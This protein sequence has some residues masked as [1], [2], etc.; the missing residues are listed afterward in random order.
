MGLIKQTLLH[1]K[2]CPTIAPSN[3]SFTEDRIGQWTELRYGT[4][5]A[6]WLAAV[7]GENPLWF[8]C[9]NAS[10]S[11]QQNIQSCGNLCTG[12]QD[13]RNWAVLIE[14]LTVPL[15]LGTLWSTA[16]TDWDWL[17]PPSN[18]RREGALETIHTLLIL[19]RLS[20]D[21]PGDI[22]SILCRELNPE[23]ICFDHDMN[24]KVRSPAELIDI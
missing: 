19:Y 18:T 1:P 4:N 2:W 15:S 8:K 3:Y 5:Y 13:C 22:R 12:I 17:L 14:P 7:S 21:Y 10:Q 6:V 9:V 20:W 24:L 23:P 11:S 16:D